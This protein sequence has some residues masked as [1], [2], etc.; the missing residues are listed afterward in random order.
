MKLQ[1][2]LAARPMP[3]AL[4]APVVIV[5]VNVS[6]LASSAAGQNTAVPL[7]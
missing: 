6:L 3:P 4:W 7:A 5:A 2:W 1:T